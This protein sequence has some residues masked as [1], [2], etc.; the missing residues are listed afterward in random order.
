MNETIAIRPPTIDG[1]PRV[2]LQRTFQFKLALHVS[3]A[4]RL[5][6]VLYAWR[7]AL[8]LYFDSTVDLIV[9]SSSGACLLVL[10]REWA[11]RQMGCADMM[12]GRGDFESTVDL[13]VRSSNGACLL[14][15]LREWDTS[16]PR[17]S[18]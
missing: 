7:L 5:A 4:W 18:S 8:V 13:I 1:L 15:L 17:L 11:A 9:R 12:D 3:G 16:M 2:V 10:L 14:V 6:L